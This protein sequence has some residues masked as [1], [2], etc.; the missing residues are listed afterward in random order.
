MNISHLNQVSANISP[1]VQNWNLFCNLF[2][3]SIQLTTILVFTPLQCVM[4]VLV[5]S[6]T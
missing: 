3:D 1:N 2:F 6:F 5:H 4:H